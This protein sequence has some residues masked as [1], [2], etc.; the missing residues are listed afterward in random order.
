MLSAKRPKHVVVALRLLPLFSDTPIRPLASS[1]PFFADLV[2]SR[3]L[4]PFCFYHA[5]PRLLYYV[6]LT[7]TGSVA[8]HAFVVFPY[9]S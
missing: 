2:S 7:S 1:C 4:P 5:P 9:L 6:Q 8:Q 3:L